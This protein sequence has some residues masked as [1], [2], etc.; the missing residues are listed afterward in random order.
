MGSDRRKAGGENIV[1]EIRKN[2]LYLVSWKVESDI[3][4][5]LGSGGT[6]YLLKSPI[7]EVEG[8]GW[9]PVKLTCSI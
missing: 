4:T 3:H 8:P 1:S 7:F 2:E 6:I 9:I 5:C